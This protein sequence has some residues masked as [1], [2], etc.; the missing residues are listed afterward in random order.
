MNR[1]RTCFSLENRSRRV[2]LLKAFLLIFY[3]H[4]LYTSNRETSLRCFGASTDRR[5]FT[6]E[7]TLSQACVHK[8]L[9]CTSL[10]LLLHSS[11]REVSEFVLLSFHP[12]EAAVMADFKCFVYFSDSNRPVGKFV[13]NHISC[14]LA[15]LVRYYN[16]LH[17]YCKTCAGKLLEY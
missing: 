16:S 5:L 12:N 11:C 7:T 10:N 3:K 17:L 2:T 13:V 6:A 9:D 1:K 8:C 15:I 4:F 14:L